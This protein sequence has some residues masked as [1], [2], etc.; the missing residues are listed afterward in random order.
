MC[1]NHRRLTICQ[2]QHTQNESFGQADSPA[3]VE[4][5]VMLTTCQ[6]Q[7]RQHEPAGQLEISTR[8]EV[9]VTGDPGHI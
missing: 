2:K 4:V 9:P 7:H 1:R 6:K 5:C 8:V 3:R